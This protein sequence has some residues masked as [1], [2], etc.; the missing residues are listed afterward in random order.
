MKR[1]PKTLIVQIADQIQET[2]ASSRRWGFESDQWRRD[3]AY[4]LRRIR[5]EIRA[6]LVHRRVHG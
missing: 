3:R 5:R 2:T 6:E 1:I 4:W